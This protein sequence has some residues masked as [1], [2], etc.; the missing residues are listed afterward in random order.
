MSTAERPIPEE[1][2]LIRDFVNTRDLNPERDEIS[3]P[4][5]LAAWLSERGLLPEGAR[6]TRAH[7]DRAN[8]FR[9][10]LRTLLLAHNE[11]GIDTTDAARAIDRAARQAGLEVRFNPDGTT[12]LVPA[13]EG[14]AAAIGRLVAIV[15]D[16]AGT[17]EWSRLK[18][19][20]RESCLWAFYDQARN[21][22]RAWCSMEVCGNRE[23]AQKF[24]E[25]HAHP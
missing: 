13:A 9:E 19:C 7:V 20:R 24:R 18:A 8:E 14:A 11:E 16:A 22:S 2:E 12:D 15:A 6:A 4:R 3:E 5:A 1:L 17:E 25:R 21:R 23:K 10:A